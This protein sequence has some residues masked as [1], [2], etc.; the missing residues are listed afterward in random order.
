M[1]MPPLPDRDADDVDEGQAV[2]AI[3]EGEIGNDEV[4]A[5]ALVVGVGGEADCAGAG[6]AAQRTEERAGDLQL[7]G[8]VDEPGR[9]Q[10]RRGRVAAVRNA[11]AGERLLTR[12]KTILEVAFRRER[13]T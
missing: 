5:V 7:D 3:G 8:S 9:V 6:K 11:G 10:R 4:V 13:R 1:F 2:V 12:A